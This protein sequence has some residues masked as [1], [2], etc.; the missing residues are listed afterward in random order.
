LN[1]SFV[2]H[3]IEMEYSLYEAIEAR[4]TDD[5]R[6]LLPPGTEEVVVIMNEFI[7]GQLKGIVVS[8]GAKALC[9]FLCNL[10][11][12]F[13]TSYSTIGTDG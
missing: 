6:S 5:L 1:I 11:D 7:T 12:N 9:R 13:T 3:H 4:L 10:N 8:R 2:W